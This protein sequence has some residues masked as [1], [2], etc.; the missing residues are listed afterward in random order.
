MTAATS[1]YRVTSIDILRGL[2]MI[3]MALDHT[4]DFFHSTAMTADPLN[5]A[6]TTPVL[7]FTRWITHFCAPG[8]VFLSGLSAWLSSQK[9]TKAAASMFLLKRGAW[10]VIVEV[11]LVTFGITFNP[12]FNLII[13]QVIW[14]IGWSMIILGLLMRISYKAILLIGIFLVF[15]H[16]VLDY[17]K[18]PGGQVAGYFWAA[19]FTAR[20]TIVALD[21]SHFIAVFYAIL[22]WTGIML[23]G[24]SAGIWFQKGFSPGKRK[25]LLLLAGIFAIA[26]FIGLRLIRGYGDPGAWDGKTLFSFLNTS[27]YPP[28]LE[29][30]CMT[31]GPSLI[32]LSLFENVRTR[33]SE[34]VSI[35]GRVPFFYYMLHF[36]LLHILLVLLF[37]ATNH[38]MAQISDPNSPFMFRPVAFGFN[39]AI[40]YLIWLAVVAAL[41]F[42][43]RWFNKVKMERSEWWLKYL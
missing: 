11:T 43:C 2:I 3:I 14:V 26:L 42:P 28:S 33:W 5:P 6:T 40:V 19:L 22:P 39:L 18:L 23:L 1:S 4:R 24:Y 36:Y 21:S 20:G 29:F 13:L 9:K 27:K 30:A 8:F 32:L 34:V 41:Y 7:F 12:F 16:N 25:R 38:S 10:L 35:Y 31:L 17:I 15:G 37:F